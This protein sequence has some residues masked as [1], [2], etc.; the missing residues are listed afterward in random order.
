[1]LKNVVKLISY[2]KLEFN[3]MFRSP[4]P[5]R[6]EGRDEDGF[7]GRQ[8]PSPY[9]KR[10]VLLFLILLMGLSSE[11][12]ADVDWQ[13]PDPDTSLL[14]LPV[15]LVDDLPHFLVEDNIPIV[16]TGGTLT[17]LDWVFLDKQDA[18]ASYLQTWNTQPI[19]DLG[20]FYGEAWIQG[21]LGVGGWGLGALTDDPRLQEFGRDTVEALA[22]DGVVS[23]AF[24]VTVPRVRPS[25]G[26]DESF[27]SGHSITSFCFAPVVT[28]YWGLEAGIPAYAL[29][30]LDGFSRIEGYHHYLS[31]VLAGATFGI[32]IGDAV[33]YK[34]KGVSVSLGP[35]QMG[36]KLAFN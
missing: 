14:H 23:L 20:D 24:N 1:L 9:A 28:K 6:G 10:T 3:S 33:V 22:L 2:L 21:G 30:C 17:V 25:G 36:L 16:L 13:S 35:G 26:N 7:D 31:D 5:L 12:F 8:Y 4:F 11:T 18:L 15:K 32:L 19:W 27:P 29:A 34:P